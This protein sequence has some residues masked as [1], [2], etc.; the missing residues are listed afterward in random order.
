LI[1]SAANGDPNSLRR[2]VIMLRASLTRP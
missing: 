1:C 2:H